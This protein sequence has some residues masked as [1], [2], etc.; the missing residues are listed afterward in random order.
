MYEMFPTNNSF[1]SFMHTVMDVV[2]SG[3]CFTPP[4]GQC[5]NPPIMRVVSIG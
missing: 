2:S 1:Y 4:V 5:I 3:Q